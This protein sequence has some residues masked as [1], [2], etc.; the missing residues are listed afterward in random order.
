[1]PAA[2]APHRTAM[3]AQGGSPFR[4]RMA[5]PP[6]AHSHSLETIMFRTISSHAPVRSVAAR[7]APSASSPSRRRG[8]GRGS[9]RALLIGFG[10]ALPVL[11]ACAG[12]T[13][14]PA[15]ATA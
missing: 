5:G 15:A 3:S 2:P 8:D 13:D 1:M 11:T 7:P 10:L 14:T 4:R 6:I 12:P 9:V